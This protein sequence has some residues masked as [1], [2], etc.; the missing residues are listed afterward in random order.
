MDSGQMKILTI[1]EIHTVLTESGLDHPQTRSFAIRK[2]AEAIF[3]D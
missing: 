2:S 3:Y 1:P